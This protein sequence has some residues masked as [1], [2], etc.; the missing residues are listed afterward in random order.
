MPK[1]KC[2]FGIHNWTITEEDGNSRTHQC[3]RC[4]KTKV[5]TKPTYEEWTDIL[6]PFAVKEIEAKFE[7]K[8]TKATTYKNGGV[9][10]PPKR[11]KITKDEFNTYKKHPEVVNMFY[12]SGLKGQEIREGVKNGDV[13]LS[14][15]GIELIVN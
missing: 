5:I 10:K 9:P 1:L 11:I 2:I 8:I 12:N 14:Y 15:K 4:F 7:V 6:Q 3:K 13:S